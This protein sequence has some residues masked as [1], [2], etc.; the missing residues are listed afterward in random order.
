MPRMDGLALLRALQQ[1]GADVTTLLADGAGHGRNG[2]RGDEGRRLRLPDQA[3]RP[4]ASEDPARQD[5][6]AARNAARGEGAAAAAS[7]A[8]R[9]RIAHRQQPRDAEDLS[10]DRAGGADERVGADHGG[11]GHRQGARGADDS[12]TEPAR[13]RFRSS[14]INCAAIPETLLE[15]EIFGHEK[16]A[17]TG[18]AERRAGL[19]RAGGPRHACSSTRSAR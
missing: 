17:F 18:A 2:R 8:W 7:R 4:P 10:G 15:S 14:P 9:V 6:R 1:Q 5:R 13:R 19:L 3:D 16:G 11:V 12:S